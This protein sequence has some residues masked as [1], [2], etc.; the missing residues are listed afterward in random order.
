MKLTPLKIELWEASRFNSM[1]IDN[2]YDPT[3]YDSLYGA[4]GFAINVPI[5]GL[6]RSNIF[7]DLHK[8]DQLDE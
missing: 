8:E 1:T 6:I 5:A 4:V 2:C 3:V 7:I